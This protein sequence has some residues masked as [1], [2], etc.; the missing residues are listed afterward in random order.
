MARPSLEIASWLKVLSGG[1]TIVKR[2]WGACGDPR[3]TCRLTVTMAAAAATST[4]AA[5]ASP[6][7]ALRPSRGATVG[8]DDPVGPSSGRS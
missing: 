6:P 2:A 7:T 3:T 1:G 5:I 4:A 8:S